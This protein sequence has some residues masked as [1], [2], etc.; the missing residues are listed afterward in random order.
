MRK[1]M[2]SGNKGLRMGIAQIPPGFLLLPMGHSSISRE[3]RS[4]LDSHQQ[5]SK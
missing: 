1:E 3:Q 2:E 4:L 5:G